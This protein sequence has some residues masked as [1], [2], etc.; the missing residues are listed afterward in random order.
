[1]KSYLTLFKN[2][3]KLN[4]RDM[5]MV[6]FAVIM[7][8]IVL[9]ILGFIYGTKPAFDGADY[10]FL[11]QSFGAVTAI[12]MCAGGLMGLPIIISDYRERKILKRFKVTP[13]SPIKLLLVELA[14]YI[15]YCMISLVT[16]AI[17]ARIFWDVRLIGNPLAFIGSWFLAMISTL[18][19]GMFVGGIAKN[20]KQSGVIA[21]ILYFPMLVFSGTTLPLEVMPKGLQ[22]VVSLF[23]FTQGIKLVKNTFLGIETDKVW[24]PVIIMLG[25]T[26]VCIALSVRLFKW[27]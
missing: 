26:I 21:S 3:L 6:I 27:E 2:E 9:V 10:S 1:M 12:S 19:I 17:A 4:I 7:P 24:L 5:N 20:S 11:Q 16:C 22:K 25:V 18:S 13:I 8:L 14:I 23:P 15:L